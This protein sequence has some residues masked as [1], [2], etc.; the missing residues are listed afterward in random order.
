LSRSAVEIT[1]EEGHGN[2]WEGLV[3]VCGFPGDNKEP[4]MNRD[5]PAKDLL[6]YLLTKRRLSISHFL[7]KSA[8]GI[9]SSNWKPSSEQTSRLI[10]SLKIPTRNRLVNSM[11]RGTLNG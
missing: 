3:E 5:N 8:T 1:N 2:N 9:W 10:K 6:E 4:F 7:D 11:I